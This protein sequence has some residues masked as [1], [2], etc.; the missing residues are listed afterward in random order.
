MIAEPN[1]N[2]SVIWLRWF[3][4]SMALLY[5]TKFLPLPYPTPELE[6]VSPDRTG[7]HDWTGRFLPVFT[8][9]W[10]VISETATWWYDNRTEQKDNLPPME[11]NQRLLL[12]GQLY[13]H[14]T[15]KERL[16]FVCSVLWSKGNTSVITYRSRKS[17]NSS[18]VPLGVKSKMNL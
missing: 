18:L 11:S 3:S 14:C 9:L 1:N 10:I 12:S 2:I 6:P 15:R 16:L 4:Y 8:V 7:W 17:L 5:L 13:Y